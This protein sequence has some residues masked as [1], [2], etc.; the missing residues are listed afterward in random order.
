MSRTL[1][2]IIEDQTRI[3]RREFR[4]NDLLGSGSELKCP[5]C[6]ARNEHLKW[7]CCQDQ[8]NGALSWRE[9]FALQ[10][11]ELE[12]EREQLNKEVEKLRPVYSRYSRGAGN[13]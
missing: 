7:T 6:R 5:R 13:D 1:K 10:L 11:A 3:D 12:K 9:A 4:L 2:Q 8:G